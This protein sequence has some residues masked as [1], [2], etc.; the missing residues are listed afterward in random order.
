MGNET[1]AQNIK[2]G[3]QLNNTVSVEWS[4]I[5]CVNPF[6]A[7]DGHTACGVNNKLYVFGGV[8]SSGNSEIVESNDLLVF[9]SDSQTWSKAPTQGQ[10]PSPRSGATMVV[11]GNK[12]YLFGGLSRDF[13]WF[14]DLH[15]YDLATSTWSE[16]DEATG[17]SPSPRD[18]I[19]SVAI[20]NKMYIFGGFGPHVSEEDVLG[21]QDDDDDYEDDDMVEDQGPQAAADFGWFDD[22][23]VFDT[24]TT[25][26]ENPRPIKIYSPTP[27]AAYG[28]CAVGNN[29]AIFGGRD[30][31]CRKSDL[32]VLDTE[33][34]KWLQ[35]TTTGRQPEPRSFHTA[36]SVGKRIVISGGRSQDNKHF[37]DIHILDTET[38]EWLQPTIKGSVPPSCGVHTA[39]VVGQHF[40]IFGGSSDFD[41]ATMQCREYYKDVYMCK[42]EDIMSGNSLPTPPEENQENAATIAN[43]TSD[44]E[45]VQKSTETATAAGTS[46]GIVNGSQ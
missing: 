14:D 23:Y 10:P 1:S 27:R 2:Y 15:C 7:R 35:M 44:L 33:S 38:K 34:M 8:V 6:P 3:Q 31:Q 9:D 16:I 43:V 39:T 21:S 36:T 40:V 41:S 25:K 11:I 13:G 4:K 28:M 5:D 29:I 20:G 45:G 22:L 42:T 12:L 19:A 37:N 46:T 17:P 18:K 24:E 32:Y 26:W 30:T